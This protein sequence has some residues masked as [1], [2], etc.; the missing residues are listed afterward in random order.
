MFIVFSFAYFFAMLFKIVGNLEKTYL[1]IEWEE[2][3]EEEKSDFFY[4]TFLMDKDF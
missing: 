3:S 4:S 1:Q 2:L